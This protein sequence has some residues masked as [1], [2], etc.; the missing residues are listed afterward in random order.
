L[1][2]DQG[3][4]AVIGCDNTKERNL[5]AIK[6][7]KGLNK[8]SKPRIKP[9]TSKQV[10]ELKD[11]FFEDDDLVIVYEQME[12]SLRAITG[13]VPGTFKDLQIAAIVKEVK[14]MLFST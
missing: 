1:S 13:I 10:V 6:R 4:P 11:M 3:G 5:V 7:L 8:A 12:I 9:V 2:L 14:H